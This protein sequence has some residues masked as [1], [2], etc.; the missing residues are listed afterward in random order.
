MSQDR[1]ST[2]RV[3]A[4]RPIRLQ[5]PATPEVVE[6]LTKDLG[7]GG[8]RCVSPT[9]F[10]VASELSLELVLSTGDEPLSVRGRT[11]WFQILPQGEQ[12]DVGIAFLDMAPQTKR[13]LSVY[14]ERLSRQSASVPA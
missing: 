4:Y 1:R 13:R 6:T 9:L 5:K 7:V 2:P 3:R 8:L 12:F 14:L 10:P 11:V